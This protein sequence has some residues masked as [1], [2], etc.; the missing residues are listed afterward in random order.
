MELY[1]QPINTMECSRKQSKDSYAVHSAVAVIRGENALCMHPGIHP[2]QSITLM[3]VVSR[4]WKVPEEFRRRQKED[5]KSELYRRLC[6]RAPDR[7]VLVVEAS[8][9]Q[10]N[11]ECVPDGG[12]PRSILRQG[13]SLPSTVESLTSIRGAVI[14]VHFHCSKA[15]EK[16]KADHFPTWLVT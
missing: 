11:D 13:M 12:S 7:V 9:I 14:S 10:W 15:E 5:E 1:Q 3:K 2:G 8:S 4:R 6:H 16:K